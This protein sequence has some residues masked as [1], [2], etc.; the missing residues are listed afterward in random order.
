MRRSFGSIKGID[1]ESYPN[2]KG[3][4]IWS[5]PKPDNAQIKKEKT[6]FESRKVTDYFRKISSITLVHQ[7]S[8][9]PFMI[10]NQIKYYKEQ[11]QN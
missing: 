10:T 2:E 9:L 8:N 11:K 1:K 6:S 5:N 7:K 3:S 4:N